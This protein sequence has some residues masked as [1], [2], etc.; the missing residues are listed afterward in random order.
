MRHHRPRGRRSNLVSSHRPRGRT[1]AN[2]PVPRRWQPPTPQ[3]CSLRRSTSPPSLVAL[4]P[5]HPAQPRPRHPAQRPAQPQRFGEKMHH[6]SLLFSPKIL[7][8]REIMVFQN[9]K[10]KIVFGPKILSERVKSARFV[11]V[12][13][14]IK[15]HN[16]LQRHT[17][18]QISKAPFPPWIHHHFLMKK[19]FSMK[20]HE[21]S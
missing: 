12:F 7:K 10:N 1:L 6:F 9:R 20:F 4:H 11:F 17:V 13:F 3:M 16:F 5:R 14:A 21:F 18:I 15:F 19:L 8:E 2:P